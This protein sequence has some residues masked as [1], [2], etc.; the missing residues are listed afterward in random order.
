MKVSYLSNN[1][2]KEYSFI[3]L[4]KKTKKEYQIH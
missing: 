4:E 1:E 2:H 3:E